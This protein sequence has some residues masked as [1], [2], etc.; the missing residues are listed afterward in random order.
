MTEVEVEGDDEAVVVL[1]D[2][3][4]KQ[5]MNVNLSPSVRQLLCI[6]YSSDKESGSDAVRV[7]IS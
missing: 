6:S 5:A 4:G 2:E 1:G 7:W 3:T